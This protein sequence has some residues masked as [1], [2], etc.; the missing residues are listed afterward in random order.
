MG[1]Y[2]KIDKS[3][4]KKAIC[5]TCEEKVSRRGSV[6]TK[7][8]TSNLRKYLMVHKDQFQS[9]LE[10]EKRRK[11]KP[12]KAEGVTLKQE[13]LKSMVENVQRTVQIT[14]EQKLLLTV[15]LK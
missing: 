3:D 14:Q 10:E 9:L 7:F 15:L 11:E 6:S 1:K 5:L 12:K 4:N 8:N 13:T 2:F